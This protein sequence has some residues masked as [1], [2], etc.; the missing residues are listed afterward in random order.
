VA[1]SSCPIRVG[2]SDQEIRVPARTRSMSDFEV[3][4]VHSLAKTLPFENTT[5]THEML[6]T[7]ESRRPSGAGSCGEA[8]PT[9]STSSSHVVVR[10]EKTTCFKVQLDTM[11]FS[12]I[13]HTTV[14]PKD[15]STRSFRQESGLPQVLCGKTKRST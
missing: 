4:R 6:R 8:P 9:T 5:S 3:T 15:E 12:T 11:K 10:V 2:Q 14:V 7:E 1:V 13:G